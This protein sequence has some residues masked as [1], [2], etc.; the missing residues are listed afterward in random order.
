MAWYPKDN[1]TPLLLAKGHSRELPGNTHAEANA[2]SK[3]MDD[4]FPAFD[5]LHNIYPSL[6]LE[7][8]LQHITVYTTLEPCSVRLSG[9]QSC[10]DKLVTAKVK[11][12]V[13]GAAEPPDFVKCEGA[14]KLKEAG[15]EVI[16]FDRF[17][18][19]CIAIARNGIPKP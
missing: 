5:K 14:K 7:I 17:Q 1:S 10:A 19:E 8:L 3:V 13:I 4:N 9:L 11:R 6:T 18:E 15:I 12:C 2:L 16:W